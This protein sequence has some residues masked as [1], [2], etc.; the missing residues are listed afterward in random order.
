MP[1]SELMISFYIAR[2]AVEWEG[3][4]ANLVVEYFRGGKGDWI[5]SPGAAS[6]M[7]PDTLDDSHTV[8]NPRVIL[9]SVSPFEFTSRSYRL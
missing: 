6:V 3:G 4:R 2:R 5:R 1:T 9:K 7:L 8:I